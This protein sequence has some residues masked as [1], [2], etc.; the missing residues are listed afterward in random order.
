MPIRSLTM[1]NNITVLR[2]RIKA[3]TKASLSNP[4]NTLDEYCALNKVAQLS[5]SELVRLKELITDQQVSASWA[6]A[7]AKPL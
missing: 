2:E 5:D 3:A 1:A 7:E 6:Y 4:L